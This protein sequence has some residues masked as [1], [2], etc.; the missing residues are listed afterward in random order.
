[1]TSKRKCQASIHDIND[2]DCDY[3][4]GLSRESKIFKRQDVELM[5]EQGYIKRTDRGYICE[6]CLD[7]ILP[8][9]Q[10]SITR[11]KQK[12]E[13]PKAENDSADPSKDCDL[14]L[15]IAK[16]KECIE[17]LIRKDVTQLYKDGKPTLDQLVQ[18]SAKEWLQ[19][20]PKQLIELMKSLCGDDILTDDKKCY[21]LAKTVEQ[22][23]YLRNSRLILPLSF[24][25]GILLYSF[26][27][28]KQA[29]TLQ[30]KTAPSSS[31]S[32][33]NRYLAEE[34]SEPVLMPPGSIRVAFDNNQVIGK[35]YMIKGDN[36][37]P[38]SVMTSTS[39]SKL[40]DS[41]IEEKVSL[42]Q[43]SGCGEI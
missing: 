36:K 13:A 16:I 24:R 29:I 14:S 28:S 15:E 3:W 34:A 9:H 37:V 41:N 12:P 1:M 2:T 23:Y 5:H 21:H 7:E 25:E 19:N 31:Y 11:R 17:P 35:T 6:R 42:N 26:T 38:T 30:C 10:Y 20:R 39:Y 18:Y 32:T 27:Y 43:N 8:E 33:I 4:F 40:S 22:L